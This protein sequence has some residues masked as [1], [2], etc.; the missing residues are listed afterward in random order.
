[1]IPVVSIVG[2]SKAGKTA[3]IERLVVELKGR[4]YSVATIKHNPHGFDID[5][6]GKDSWR[7]ARSGSDAV[8]ISSPQRLAIIRPMDHDATIDEIQSLLGGD[9]DIVLTEGFRAGKAPKIE[10]HRKELKEGLLSSPKE[11][12]ALVSDEPL[13]VDVPQFSAEDVAMIADLIEERLISR[14]A[15]QD[16][17]LFVNGSPIALNPFT[18]QFIGNTLLGM[19]SALRGVGRIRSLEVF[20]RKK[21]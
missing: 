3:L 14:R 11:L 4:G 7:H 10:V 5:Q 18:K 15:A 20:V 17:M 8:V 13:P 19:I 21:G 2:K 12:L 1:M 6:P 9:F 16:A